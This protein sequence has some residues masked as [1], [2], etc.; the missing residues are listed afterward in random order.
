MVKRFVDRRSLVR[1]NHLLWQAKSEHGNLTTKAYDFGKGGV[2]YEYDTYPGHM[3][4][5]RKGPPSIDQTTWCWYWGHWWKL[6]N[7]LE[8]EGMFGESSKWVTFDMTCDYR[9]VWRGGWWEWRP[10]QKIIINN[11]Q[12]NRFANVTQ[13][14]TGMTKTKVVQR[15][16]WHLLI[17][18]RRLAEHGDWYL[19]AFGPQRVRRPEAVD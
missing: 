1:N 18:C 7:W 6:I 12:R 3:E 17:D 14:Y 11:L 19:N 5:W 16:G 8:A 10:E 13:R 4:I 15:H 9:N 2:Y